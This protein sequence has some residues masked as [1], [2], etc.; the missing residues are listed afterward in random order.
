MNSKCPECELQAS[1]KAISC[2]HCGYPLKPTSDY[3]GIVVRSDTKMN[4]MEISYIFHL[5]IA[6]NHFL[7]P[8]IYLGVS[9]SKPDKSLLI[10]S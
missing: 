1:D 8:S 9:Y 4:N 5:C 3:I 2:Q 7:I 6:P 10:T